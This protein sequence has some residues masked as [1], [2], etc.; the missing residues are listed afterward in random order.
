MERRN[1]IWF[2]LVGAAAIIGAFILHIGQRER[3]PIRVGILHSMTG[4]M[5]PSESQLAD[6][7]LLAIDEIN[8]AGGVLGRPVVPVVGDGRSDW[9]T[10]AAEAE[11]LISQENVS[12]IFG[13]YTSASRKEVKPIVEKHNNLFFYPVPYE[14]VESSRN[15]VYNG[16]APNQ[17]Y[18]PAVKWSFDN[19]GKRF[20]LVGSDYIWPR[21]VNVLMKD[22][23]S[24]LRGEVVGEEYL[25]VGSE[26]VEEVV[27]KIVRHQPEVILSTVVGTTNIP[28]FDQ[29]RAAG[30]TSHEI[31]VMAFAISEG[32]LAYMDP[33]TLASNY[34][35][36]SYFQSVD[37]DTNREFIRAFKDKYGED[38]VVNA[39]IEA[40]YF[41]AHIWAQAVEEAGTTAVNPVRHALADQSY[42][43]PGG[44]VF[45]D[46][47]NL[48]TWKNVRIG[49][50]LDDGQYDI[51]WSSGK[52]VRPVPYPIYRTRSEWV[53]LMESFYLAWGR[54]WANPGE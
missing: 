7:T 46:G 2:L 50:I 9:P 32:E 17:L 31:P 54:R 21:M 8:R 34:S 49:R 51:L 30:I 10:F 11:R 42:L 26:E 6:A 41:G 25:L 19:L 39:S 4:V 38:R 37:S 3:E 43:A 45:V 44:M 15:I 27:E 24:G 35:A 28:F 52:P 33:E 29:L 5:A 18:V 36:W 1:A 13:G 23:I 22:I 47:E 20:F 53:H 40:G 16:A 12:A 48:H 14:G